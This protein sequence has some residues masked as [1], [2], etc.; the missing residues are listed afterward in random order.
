L[1]AGPPSPTDAL[2]P[3]DTGGDAAPSA[4]IT[5]GA[6]HGPSVAVAHYDPQTGRYAAPDGHVYAQTDLVA[7]AKTWQDLVFRADG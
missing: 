5:D 3:P 6:I 4:F 2:A 1:P 7:P